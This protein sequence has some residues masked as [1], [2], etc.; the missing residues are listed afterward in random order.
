MATPNFNA[1]LKGSRTLPYPKFVKVLEELSLTIGPKALGAS[2]MPPTE[3]PE[4]IRQGIDS[5]GLKIR[6]VANQAEIDVS[7]LS[8]FLNGSRTTPIRNVEKLMIVLG[9][10]IVRYIRPKKLK[11]A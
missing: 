5:A 2:I 4:I 8:A 1:F 6:E 7:C 3:L 11:S 9:L 10:D